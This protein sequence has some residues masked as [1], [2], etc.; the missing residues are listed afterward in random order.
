MSQLSQASKECQQF[1]RPVRDVIELIGGKWKLPVIVALSF[2]TQRFKQLERLLEG[3][4]PRMLSKELKDLEMNG[5]VSRKVYDT[6]PVT[7]EYSLTEYGKSL[8]ELIA[9]LRK[10][11][12]DHRER[13]MKPD[14]ELEKE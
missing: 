13:I 5:L 10:W 6:T 9:V 8:D 2:G 11:G 7:V 12:L 3:I 1:I 4:T 14:F